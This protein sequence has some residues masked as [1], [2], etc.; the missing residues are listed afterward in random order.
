[1]RV[2]LSSGLLRAEF[3]I[4][5]DD[6]G[7][8]L[9]VVLVGCV[10]VDQEAG[11]PTVVDARLVI[12]RGGGLLGGAPPR[13]EHLQTPTGLARGRLLAVPETLLRCRQ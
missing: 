10:D 13:V 7:A 3:V 6:Y 12:G 8:E 2:I 9:E 1:M 11:S 5:L 4:A